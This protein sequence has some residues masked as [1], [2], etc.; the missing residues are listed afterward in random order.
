MGNNFIKIV[1]LFFLGLLV[2]L[3]VVNIFLFRSRFVYQQGIN[4]MNNKVWD[5]ALASFK[6]AEER[7]PDLIG[8][9]Y[10]PWDLFNIH[11]QK[12]IALNEKALEMWKDKGLTIW[13]LTKY[14]QSKKEL[15]KALVIDPDVYIPAYWLARTENALEVLYPKLFPKKQTPY[16]AEPF[17]QE[18]IR[19]RPNGITVHYAYARYLD[20]KNE[21]QKL[22]RI[23]R[24]MTEIYPK[25]YHHLKK[26]GFFSGSLM[27]E[28]EKGLISALDKGTNP[29][30][31]LQALADL[32]SVKKD[33]ENASDTYLKSLKLRPFSNTGANYIR[34]GQLLLRSEN[35][36]KSISW[37]T[38][39]LTTQDNFEKTLKWIYYIHIKEGQLDQFIRFAVRFEKD[40][41]H[42]SSILDLQIAE[43]WMQKKDDA[44]ATTRLLRLNTREPNAQAYYLLAKIAQ[45]DKN[46]DQ[47]EI[48]AQ[49]ATT[50]N[51][52][53]AAYYHLFSRALAQQKK[54]ASAEEVATKALQYVLKENPG[55]FNQ[56]AWTRWH[57][58][59]YAQAITDW[60]RAFAIMPDR[61]D[62]PYY[63]AMAYERE[64]LFKEGLG[65]IKK[66]IALSPENQ[67][68]KAL[69]KRLKTHK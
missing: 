35:P 64:G 29:R 12:G 5:K 43:A 61:S 41:D 55:Y 50:L 39:A 13:V 27:D 63:I 3:V 45:K 26:E 56:R 33:H 53:N 17:Y 37:F 24:Y 54:Y 68:Y 6:R 22:T 21:T 57:Q 8:R 7:I 46:W 48:S 2:L 42:P 11:T 10:A 52:E 49:K 59:K 30:H 25:S 23:V 58:K 16:D 60:K 40:I 14:R 15:R 38:K 69:E 1:K 44:L 34:M 9:F 36:D 4:H 20:Y 28:M 18:A 51:R 62:F 67:K 47:V 31:A 32:Y 19:L 66:A 65:F